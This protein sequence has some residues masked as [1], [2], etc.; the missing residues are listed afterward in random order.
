MS[1]TANQEVSVRIINGKWQPCFSCHWFGVCVVPKLRTQVSRGYYGSAGIPYN[2][3]YEAGQVMYQCMD[4]IGRGNSKN[5]D[6]AAE[7]TS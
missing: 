4:Y 2:N 3:S 7:K 5:I 1:S 6:P